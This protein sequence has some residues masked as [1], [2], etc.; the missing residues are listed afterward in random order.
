MAKSAG[1]A[2]SSNA[3]PDFDVVVV[4]AGFAGMYTLHR[5]RSMG[6]TARVIEAG[7]GVG[8]TWY[9]NRY[10]GARCDGESML[11]S[12]G[13]SDELQQEWTWSE[14]YAAQPEILAYANHVADRFDLRRDIQFDTRVTAA[15]FDEQRRTWR[16]TTDT[17]AH[18]SS[19]YV[20]MATGCL[21][22]AT[23]PRLA[24]EE[25]FKGATY[26]TGRWPH[27]GVDFRGKRVAVVGTGS[28]GIQAIP[29]IA[30]EAD[31]LTVFQRTAQ[32]TIPAWNGPL[33]PAAVKAVK[34]GY[35][36]LRLAQRNSFNGNN[37]TF[38]HP[39]AL[40]VSDP[41]R[42]RIYEESW[43]KGGFAFLA[44]FSDLLFDKKAN[45]TAAEFVRS[46]LREIVTDPKV[47][48]LLA[49]KS[50]FGCKRLCVDT[51]YW[52]TYNRPNVSLVDISGTPIEKLVPEGLVVGG[53]TYA[54]D[55]IV[56]A[57]GFDAVTGALDRIDIRSTS[58]AVLKQRWQDGPRTYLGLASHGFP[59]LFTITGPQSP[60]VLTNMIPSIEHHVEWITDCLAY[61]RKT[62][63][64]R[65]EATREAEDAWV[66]E[67]SSLADG[68]L[69][70]QCN[71]WY[72][73]ANVPG[74]PRV[75]LAYVAGIPPY[76]K[77]CEEVVE[78]GYEGFALA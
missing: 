2:S 7:S 77:R 54:V 52:K 67:V 30:A 55:V 26:H 69:R 61:M 16:V 74:K 23:A 46:K 57:T 62:G 18:L 50:I 20:V 10:P 63:K 73:G 48:D 5:L 9:W 35:P 6:L 56:F 37:T 59:N 75:Y 32:Y 24:G 41:E 27:A 71:S 58:G 76:K 4:G 21:S 78:R 8:G 29:R 45:D 19:R 42:Q 15:T 72:V 33:D 70:P 12:Y 22:M 13:F 65:I 68:T 47:A 14:R 40:A 51:D 38:S 44:T 43:Q 1:S 17:G 34:A 66:T 49:P 31:H 64:T 60:S 25:T 53:R 3:V 36:A 39:S 11:Y 28:S